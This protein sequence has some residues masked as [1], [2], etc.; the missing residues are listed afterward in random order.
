[1]M[2]KL[3]HTAVTVST[4]LG[5]R[6]DMGTTDFTIEFI[7]F[8]LYYISLCFENS[9]L[10]NKWI[11]GVFLSGNYSDCQNSSCE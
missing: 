7:L 2:I 4:M 3:A 9:L 6:F 8:R 11:S 1:M 10:F 5:S